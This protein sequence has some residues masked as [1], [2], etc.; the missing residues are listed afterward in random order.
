MFFKATTAMPCILLLWSWYGVLHG[1]ISQA[2]VSVN[3]PPCI[4]LGAGSANIM[5][6]LPL[7]QKFAISGAV[8]MQ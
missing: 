2:E 4:P 7:S 5:I 8:E 6:F 3:F 1:P